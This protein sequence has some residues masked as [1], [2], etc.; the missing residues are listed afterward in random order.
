MTIK[1]CK[2]LVGNLYHKKGI[3]CTHNNFRISSNIMD[4]Y[5]KKCIKYLNSLKKAQLKTYIDMN[6]ETKGKAKNE[7]KK[8]FFRVVNC[9][10]FRETMKNVGEIVI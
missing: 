2:E 6:T 9:P 4:Q 3:H 5:Y 8:I 7:F 10:V 1:K